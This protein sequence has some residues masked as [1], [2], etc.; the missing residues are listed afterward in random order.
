MADSDILVSELDS[1]SQ[2]NTDDLLL[3]T[4]PDIG[5]ET[6][7]ISKKATTLAVFNKALKG[8]NY[9]TDLPSFT[10]KTVL[11]GM[12]ELKDD[13]NDSLPS[14][15]ASGAIATFTTD[16]D[17]KLKSITVEEGASTVTLCGANLLSVNSRV[18]QTTAN[19]IYTSDDNYI[20]LNG[21]K[22]G[23]GYAV[24][25]NLTMTLSAGTYYL[26]A[27]V[28]SGTASN[29]VSLY[30]FDG[31]DNISSDILGGE[32][33]MTLSAPKTF[34]FR[35]AIWA[36][37]TVLS[38]Y[39][40]GI[41]VSPTNIG[42]YSEYN[43]SVYTVANKDNIVTLEGVNNIFADVGSVSVEY[44]KRYSLENLANVTITSASSGQV[45]KY[46]GSKWV[47]GTGGGGGASALNDLT[48]VTITSASSGQVLK[49][50]GSVW[51]NESSSAPWTDVTGTLVS[52]NTS[53]T[54]SNA[55]ITTSSTLDIFTDTF[56]VNPTNMTVSTGS[57]TL[58]FEARQS[59]LGVKVRVS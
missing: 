10:D 12:A 31:T 50:N 42:D 14:G 47:N 57:V 41:V 21:T 6:G 59:D 35:M 46:D 19:V 34:N 48:D 43:G 1:A 5:S 49:F 55:A 24:M 4:Q 58:T 32:K 45:L 38:N 13:L 30:A 18:D 23:G 37:G 53:L 54:L 29:T 11:G 33:T 26:K 52:G 27:F 3:M 39:K 2:I 40:I 22:N 36:D 9:S 28:I 7:Y 8:V 17:M 20:Y 25:S 44:F 51:V 15:T 16:L 56:G